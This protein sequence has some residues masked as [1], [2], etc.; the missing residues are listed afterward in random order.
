MMT[1]NITLGDGKTTI[2]T[3][4][5]DD[6]SNGVAFSST[7]SPNSSNNRVEEGSKDYYLIIK[8]T[9]PESLLTLI[10][11]L[12]DARLKMLQDAGDKAKPSEKGYVQSY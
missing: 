10:N 4:I 3:F 12:K 6:G 8:S 9:S 7:V 1:S 11:S 5:G 2:G